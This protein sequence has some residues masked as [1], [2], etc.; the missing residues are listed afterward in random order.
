[1]TL[2]DDGLLSMLKIRLSS[3]VML[4]R[5]PLKHVMVL[6]SLT[7]RSLD[8]LFNDHCSWISVAVDE[9][10]SD[11]CHHLSQSKEDKT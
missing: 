6:Q 3:W 8:D 5:L 2:G 10:T 7:Y 1:M 9:L 4:Q 11:H